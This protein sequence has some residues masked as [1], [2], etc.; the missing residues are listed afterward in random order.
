MVELEKEVD[1]QGRNGYFSM[2]RRGWAMKCGV[3]EGGDNISSEK[4]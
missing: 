2:R 4:E 1:G 3:V